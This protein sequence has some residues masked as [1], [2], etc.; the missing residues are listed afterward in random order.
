M[1]EEGEAAVEGRDYSDWM[2]E[3][4]REAAALPLALL[5]LPGSHDSL[6]FS[7]RRGGGAG[8]DQPPCIRALTRCFPRLS[9]H[10]LM[11]WSRTQ[12]AALLH[13]LRGGVRYF[14]LR[15]DAVEEEGCREYRVI[16]CLLGARARGL[17]LQVREFLDSHLGEV[18]VI[19]LQHT[20]SFLPSDHHTLT[21]FLLA[22]FRG[23]LLPWT[24]EA[25][26]TPLATLQATNCRVIL[27]YPA[28]AAACPLVWPRA[29][30]PTPWPDTTDPGVLG[31]ALARGLQER[32]ED[33]L[34]VS[35]GVLTPSPLTVLLHPLAGLR[36]VCSDKAN[37]TVLAWLRE[38]DAA[39]N[40][41]ITDFVLEDRTALAIIDTIIQ[42]NRGAATQVENTV[43]SSDENL[44]SDETINSGNPHVE[45]SQM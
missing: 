6:T 20:Y 31:R 38:T 23:L 24:P 27:V 13:Q 44:C 41:V 29:G 7:L 30:C 40:I 25:A 2:G 17:L 4:P 15:L 3:L 22:T 43:I 10:I 26:S 35:Q 32:R 1:L 5:S 14:D 8:P 21:S 11:R 18:V 19:D 12:E 33:R 39:P 34:F 16:H 9:S 42:R 37:T 45:P 36:A 28:M